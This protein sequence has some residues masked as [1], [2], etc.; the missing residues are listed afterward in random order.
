[1]PL[2][3]M[4]KLSDTMVEGTLVKWCKAKGDS[5]EVGDVLVGDEEQPCLP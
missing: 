5:I 3:S 4:P 2:V 1:M